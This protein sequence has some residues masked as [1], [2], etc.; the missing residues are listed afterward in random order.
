MENLNEELLYTWLKLSSSIINDRLT[1][2]MPYNES[3]I[4]NILYRAQKL[5][6]EKKL[7]ATELC[8]ET[9]MLKSQMNRTLNQMERKNL[10]VR[11]RSS[12]DRRN[13]FIS[14]NPQQAE[15]YVAQHEKILKLVDSIIN[16]IGQEQSQLLI[17]LLSKVS[18]FANESFPK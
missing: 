12:Q 13:I 14:M 11:E 8:N 17:E 6:P 9:H 16:N 7:T 5:N 15:V 2:D 18:H 1:S 4:C 3:L 10:I